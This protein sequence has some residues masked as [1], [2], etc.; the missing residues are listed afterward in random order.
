MAPPFPPVPGVEHRFAQAGAVRLHYAEAGSG[1]PVVLLHGW[2]QHWY[3]W[4]RVI[5]TLAEH[6]RLICP[7]LRGFGWSDAPDSSYAKEELATDVV[8]LLDALELERV[9]LVGHDWGGFVG[10]LT[11]LNAPE[12]VSAFLALAIIHPWPKPAPPRL[13]TIPTL[14][15]QPLLATPGVGTFVQRHT[16]FYRAVFRAAGGTRIWSEE[17]QR[18]FAETF[19]DRAHAT[20]ASR[21]YRTFLFSELPALM[22]GRYAD[23]RLTVPT[24]MLVGRDDPVIEEAR[25]DGWREH[26]DDMAVEMV[27]GGHFLPEEKPALVTE[28]ARAL[29]ATG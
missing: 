12:R 18:A 21:L 6:H 27:D 16:P 2:P 1:P 4:R 23:R 10:F 24:R 22:R 20:A 7:D 28:R 11:A 3:V 19:Q 14:L 9:G 5:P 17:E 13:G 15:Y 29:F 26:A 25:L 8:A